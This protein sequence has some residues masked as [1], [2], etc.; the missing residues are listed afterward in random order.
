MV[1][2]RDPKE[3][4]YNWAP[5]GIPRGMLTTQSTSSRGVGP[6]PSALERVNPGV[7]A[8]FSSAPGPILLIEQ[9]PRAPK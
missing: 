4:R 1:T 7:L 9:P 6:D 8:V 5:W 3:V 2:G